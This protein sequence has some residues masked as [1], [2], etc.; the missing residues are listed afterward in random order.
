MPLAELSAES[1]AA[2]ATSAFIS[3]CRSSSTRTHHIDHPCQIALQA[4]DKGCELYPT[5]YALPTLAPLPSTATH[6]APRPQSVRCMCTWLVAFTLRLIYHPADL[7][8]STGVRKPV[9]SRSDASNARTDKPVTME[10]RPVNASRAPSRSPAKQAVPSTCSLAKPSLVF[11]CSSLR[12]AVT[13]TNQ[14]SRC[15]ASTKGSISGES[16]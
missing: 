4:K 2:Q 13:R 10:Q 1:A 9:S 8:S 16:Q 12:P 5:S 14:L 11:H 7:T 6:T 15:E 3:V